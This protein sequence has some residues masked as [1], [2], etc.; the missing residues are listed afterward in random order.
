M[1]RCL[2]FLLNRAVPISFPRRRNTFGHASMK[3]NSS[4]SS[5]NHFSYTCI[6]FNYKNI[7]GKKG[8]G[9]KNKLY[10][11]LKLH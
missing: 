6:E 9:S 10:S 1:E 7:P 8:A 5:D 2:K 4:L 11:K 3:K